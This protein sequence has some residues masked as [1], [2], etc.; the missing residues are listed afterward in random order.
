MWTRSEHYRQCKCL[1]FCS[2]RRDETPM[3]LRSNKTEIEVI[4]YCM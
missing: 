3:K 1:G 4:S 2:K